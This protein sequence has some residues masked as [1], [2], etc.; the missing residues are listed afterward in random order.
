[1]ACSGQRP[2]SPPF[3]LPQVVLV[4]VAECADHYTTVLR[5]LV[6]EKGRKNMVWMGQ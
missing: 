6:S 5:K 3:S 4:A 2:T 1:M